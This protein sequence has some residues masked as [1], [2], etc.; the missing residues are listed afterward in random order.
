MA[1]VRCQVEVR[2][3]VM[4]VVQLFRALILIL[5]CAGTAGATG[6][7]KRIALVIGIG[8]YQFAPELPT[9]VND[10]RAIG[11]ALRKLGYEVEEAYDPDDRAFT[12][13]L[14]DFGVHAAAA[15]EAVVFY[16]GHALQARG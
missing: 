14:R 16:A 9:A 12:S 2:L 8:S 3:V 10:A 4:R 6:A 15:D 7:D 5:L 11:T 13:R 1:R